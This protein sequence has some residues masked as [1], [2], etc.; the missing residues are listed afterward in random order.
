[1]AG[2]VR[3]P[4]LTPEMLTARPPAAGPVRFSLRETLERDRDSLY[5]EFFGRM[6]MRYEVKPAHDVPL[7]IDIN[8]QML[9][10]LLMVSGKMHGS[11]NRR[12]RAC[13]DDGLDDFGM[14][15]NLGGKYV[16]G[17]DGQEIVL[18]DGEAVLI[19]LGKLFTLM[20][21]PPGN[22][23]AMRFPRTQMMPRI[24]GADDLC[25]RPLRAD[26]DALKL[27]TR[28]ADVAQLDDTVA[29]ADV[30]QHFVGHIYDLIALTL[31]ATRDAAEL[32]R[33]RGLRAARLHAIKRDI[34][35]SLDQPDLSVAAL[36]LRHGLT[37]RFVQ[38]LFE[39]EG[40]TFTQYLLAE[41]LARAHRLLTD[42]HRA[43]EKI[44]TVAFDAGFADVSYFNRAF[45]RRFGAAP[46]DVRAAA[47]R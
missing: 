9:P 7:D 23:L 11:E 24:V 47:T 34:G 33:G 45:R 26:S 43:G 5:H 18:E 36:A 20:H 19:S 14:A 31:G 30:R 2:S 28:Y 4:S 6:V 12:T 25:M 15:V 42:P 27:L 8:L 22:F 16:V 29:N 17:Q 35:R 44:S 46:S 10:G 13:V 21:R 3:L 41:R 38:R 37:P 1:M 32:A 39:A 40:T